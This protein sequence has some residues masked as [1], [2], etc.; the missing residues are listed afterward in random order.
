MTNQI[1]T[2]DDVIVLRKAKM[3]MLRIESNPNRDEFA[4]NILAEL[5]GNQWHAVIGKKLAP[6][7]WSLDFYSNSDE[8]IWHTY[9]MDN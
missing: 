8:L 9:L 1:Y 4:E 2:K 6:H 3:A 7:C 5:K